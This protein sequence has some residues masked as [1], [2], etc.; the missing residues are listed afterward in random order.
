MQNSWLVQCCWTSALLQPAS[1]APDWKMVAKTFGKAGTE[2]PDG[3][4]RVGLLRTDLKVSLDG[5]SLKPG[6]ALGGWIAF[7]PMGNQAMVMGDIVLTQDEANPVMKK[8]EETGIEITALHNH[9]LRA[10]PMT[11]YMH[12][13]GQGDPVTLAT[14]LHD[15][16]ALSKTPMGNAAQT[17][18]S[19][20]QIGFAVDQ[21]IGRKGKASESVYQFSI[22][23]AEKIT[24]GGMAVP[25]SMGSAIAINFQPTGAGKAAITGDF[26]LIASEVNPVLR[27]LR[28][29]GIE[30]TALHSHM[31]EE[32]PRLFFM[33]FWANDDAAKLALDKMNLA[34]S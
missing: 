18:A 30:V 6:F 3:V 26:V 27:T 17:Q 23:R 7:E 19:A 8:L 22:P 4:Y 32:Q 16:L 31:L 5:V 13:F 29:N 33:H 1:A 15:G 12:V 2:M 11:L 24:D 21:A 14:A 34:N 25:A 20:Q 28:D 10:E 9:L